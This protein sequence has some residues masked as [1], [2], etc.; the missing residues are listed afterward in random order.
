M[1]NKNSFDDDGRI[2][3]DMS[4]IEGPN[5]FSVR[6]FGKK[7]KKAV[8]SKSDS[9]MT[10]EERRIYLKA[11]LLSTLAIASVFIVACAI[12]ILFCQHIWLK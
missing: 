2:V 1:A 8:M 7:G 3:A 11:A 9:E 5:M 6:G 4:G 10:E 12:F